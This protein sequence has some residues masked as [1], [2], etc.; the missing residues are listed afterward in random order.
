DA[1]NARLRQLHQDMIER[2]AWKLLWVPPALAYYEGDGPFKDPQL[3][4]FT[5]RVIFSCWR[6]VPKAIAAI[7]SYEAERCMIQTFRKKARNTPEARK[8][9]RPLLRFTFRQGN[10]T[11]MSVLALILPCR[12]LAQQFDPLRVG[13]RIAAPG[14]APTLGALIQEIEPQ[15]DRMLAPLVERLTEPSGPPDETWYWA[16]PLLLDR[17]YDSEGLERWFTTANL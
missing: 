14:T 12:T 9:R 16:A 13:E 1:G 4:E 2:G 10:P 17:E 5:K 15:I 6:V 11:G 7:L 3:A 8:K